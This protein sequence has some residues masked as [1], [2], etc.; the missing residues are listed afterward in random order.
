MIT[1]SRR[2]DLW[3]RRD[4]LRTG[5]STTLAMAATTARLRYA[6]DRR[7]VAVKQTTREEPG[8]HP[9]HVEGVGRASG[10]TER[11]VDGHSDHGGAN[12]VGDGVLATAVVKRIKQLVIE[13]HGIKAKLVTRRARTKTHRGAPATATR[14]PW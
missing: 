10:T 13:Q 6:S 9:K 14:T 1:T 4:Q 12:H 3:H 7:P 2:I 11:R 5:P 8:A